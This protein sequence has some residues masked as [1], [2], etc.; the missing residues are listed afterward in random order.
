MSAVDLLAQI[1][2]MCESW[3]RWTEQ[4]FGDQ[5]KG[6]N[7]HSALDDLSED[8]VALIVAAG[9]KLHL[10]QQRVISELGEKQPGRAVRVALRA[11]DPEKQ[12]RSRAKAK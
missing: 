11:E 3:R 12:S 4:A 2:G 6:M 9:K 8:L 10:L 1:E 5:Q 7:E